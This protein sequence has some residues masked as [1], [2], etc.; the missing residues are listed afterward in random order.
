MADND[1]EVEVKVLCTSCFDRLGCE[2]I[3]AMIPL[4]ECGSCG[5]QCLGYQT[6]VEDGRKLT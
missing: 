1:K 5:R 6:E 3:I 2:R 4:S